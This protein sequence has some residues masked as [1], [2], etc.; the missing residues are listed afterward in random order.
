MILALGLEEELIASHHGVHARADLGLERIR[1]IFDEVIVVARVRR[2]TAPKHGVKVDG[3]GVRIEAVTGDGLTGSVKKARTFVRIAREAGV[4]IL[5][6]PGRLT[7]Q[8][9]EALRI[10]RTPFGYELAGEPGGGMF[11]GGLARASLREQV[12][13]AA[14]TRYATT[15]Y[16]QER[17]PPRP[18]TFT[19]GVPD[20]EL[21]DAWFDAPPAPIRS[22]DTL[23]LAFVG[24]FTSPDEGLELLLEALAYTARPHRLDVAGEGPLRAALEQRATRLGVG[25]RVSFRGEVPDVRAFL[26]A[27]DLFVSPARTAPT[28]PAALLTAMAVRLPCLATAVGATSEAIDA[29]ELVPP[30]PVPIARA[31]DALAADA[32]R[33]GLVAL[34]L[35]HRARAFRTSEREIRL[36]AFLRAVRDAASR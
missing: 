12:G 5:R 26:R 18:G 25:G 17:Y 1:R 3:P 19:V 11:R 21:P 7:T 22:G 10:T 13:A 32:P 24:G 31:I 35:R 8:L 28:V 33:R 20:V 36:A 16:L 14:A 4:A 27:R 29:T 34:A 6:G 9:R 30:E 2:G 15:S 23:D